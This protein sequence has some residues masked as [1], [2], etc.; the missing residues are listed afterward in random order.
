MPDLRT[1]LDLAAGAIRAQRLRAFLT[2]L[3]ITMGVATLMAV[4]TLVQGANTYVEQKIANLGTNVFQVGRFPFATTSWDEMI[5]ARRNRDITMVELAVVRQACTACAAVGAVATSTTRVRYRDQE[6]QDQF[7]YGTT[8]NMRSIDT[9]T[10]ELGRA[11]TEMEELHGAP[12]CLIGDAVRSR[13]FAGIDPLGKTIRIGKDEMLVIGTFTRIGAVLGQ[14]QDNFVVIPLTAFLRQQGLRQSLILHAKATGGERL[15]E[16]AQDQARL[17][18]RARRHIGAG[19]R[20]DFYIG[21]AESYMNL[22]RDISKSFFAVFL[23]LSSISA[24]VGGIVIMNIMLVSVTERTKEIGI[25]RACGARQADI[26]RQFLT[27]SVLLCL[28]GGVV[29]VLLG[30]AAALAVRTLADFP[31]AVEAWSAALG[32]LLSCSIGLFFGIY[33]AVKAAKLDPVVALRTE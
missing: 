31:A 30:F 14:E 26:L 16:Q 24:V 21:T 33:P 12:V 13:L 15:F 11:Y 1:N 28:A 20:E 10:V 4:I 18:L 5:R 7:L 9:R 23:M 17:A 22:W 27:E 3:G 25:R 32:V 8:A 2:V 29:G 19:G 6:L